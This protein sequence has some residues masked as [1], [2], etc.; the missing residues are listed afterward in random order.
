MDITKHKAKDK[1]TRKLKIIQSLEEKKAALEVEIITERAE[2]KGME[3][4]YSM[5]PDDGKGDQCRTI[6]PTSEAGKAQK[7]L[8]KTGNPLH[9]SK[10]LEASKKANNT[11]NRGALA[12]TLR[13]YAK[14]GEVFTI[15]APNTFG[16]I[17]WKDNPP[18][19]QES[20]ITFLQA[21]I[22]KIVE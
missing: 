7:T 20:Q 1:I 22:N 21:G 12:S 15:T 14:R 17:E 6:R 5:L 13:T 16:L 4:I 18:D 10:I 3:D 8:K 9:I 2:L 11:K 19:Q